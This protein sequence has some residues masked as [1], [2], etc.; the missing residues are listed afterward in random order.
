MREWIIE[1][2]IARA[3]RTPYF[4]LKQADGSG[5]MNRYWL[6]PFQGVGPYEGRHGCYTAKWY[7][8][9]FVWLCQ[10]FD[11]SIRIHE[12][13]SSDDARAFHDHPWPY[14]T[15]ILKNGYIEHTPRYVSGIYQG[16]T[17]KNIKPGRILFR[18]AQS[19]HRLKVFTDQPAWTLF[20]AFK[21]QQRWGF[22]VHPDAKMLYTEYAKRDAK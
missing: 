4:H 15:W 8:N 6:V 20:I 2:L 9:P 12:I 7:R 14:V 22:L 19:W 3:K 10:K 21:Y 1:R 13:L 5:Y 16:E 17:I 11:V 18:R